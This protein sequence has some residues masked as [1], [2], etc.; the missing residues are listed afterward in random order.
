MGQRTRGARQFRQRHTFRPRRAVRA[1]A[2]RAAR[3]CGHGGRHLL[4]R[5]RLRP[6][7]DP[8]ADRH[9]AGRQRGALALLHSGV[10]GVLRAQRGMPWGVCAA[11]AT[12]RPS[13][14]AEGGAV[15]PAEAQQH[16]SAPACSRKLTRCLLRWLHR[17]RALLSPPLPC[18]LLLFQGVS[19]RKRSEDD[20]ARSIPA[21]ENQRSE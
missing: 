1:A 15:V 6:C 17:S 14:K 11:N 13:G 5:H 12:P 4:R 21:D 18:A 10:S 16:A 3:C 8:G 20:R 9:H 19:G 7:A 2:L